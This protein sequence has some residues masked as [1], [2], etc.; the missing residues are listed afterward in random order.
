MEKSGIDEDFDF[1]IFLGHRLPKDERAL[2]ITLLKGTRMAT[3]LP[4]VTDR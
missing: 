4:R 1:L 2:S 3:T